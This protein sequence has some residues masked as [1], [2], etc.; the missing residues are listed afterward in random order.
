MALTDEEREI[1]TEHANRPEEPPEL[2]PL[3]RPLSERA[4]LERLADEYNEGGIRRVVE[5]MSQERS[6]LDDRAEWLERQEGEMALARASLQREQQLLEQRRVELQGMLEDLDDGQ[7]RWAAAQAAEARRLSAIDEAERERLA[8]MAILYAGSKEAW[9]RR[10]EPQQ[11]A[12][13][14]FC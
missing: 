12:P 4:M 10:P 1:L 13:K 7:A 14:S 6:A 9:W 3:R 8:E 2:V 11:A 5:T